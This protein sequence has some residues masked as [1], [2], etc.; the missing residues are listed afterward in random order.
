MMKNPEDFKDASL[1]Y[2]EGEELTAITFLRAYLQL[3]FS[4]A[5]L[6]AYVWPTIKMNTDTIDHHN[7]QYRNKLC[8]CIGKTVSVAAAQPD[9]KLVILFDDGGSIEI[10]LRRKDRTGEEAAMFQDGTGKLWEVW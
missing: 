5:Y 4:G 3:H 2:L 8:E 1:A 6:N 10:S 7:A 9:E